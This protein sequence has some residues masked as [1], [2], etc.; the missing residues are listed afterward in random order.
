[1]EKLLL[2]FSI[3][4]FGIAAIGCLFKLIDYL[5]DKPTENKEAINDLSVNQPTTRPSINIVSGPISIISNFI[6]NV[7]QI[8]SNNYKLNTSK[9][10]F[11]REVVLW[12]GTILRANGVKYYPSI[13]VKYN[14]SPKYFGVYT[15]SANSITIYLKNHKGDL[16]EICST[17]LHEVMHHIQSKKDREFKKLLNYKKYGYYNNRIEVEARAFEKQYCQICMIDLCK[18]GVISKC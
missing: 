6:S 13:S 16:S 9:I 8:I 3:T 18:K 14:S 12:T 4:C 15:Y 7:Q 1:L 17:V 5:F 2:I 11:C 10:Q